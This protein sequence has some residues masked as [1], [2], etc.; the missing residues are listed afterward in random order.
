MPF[1]C[2]G[3]DCVLINNNQHDSHLKVFQLRQLWQWGFMCN[4]KYNGLEWATISEKFTYSTD[5]QSVLLNLA[6]RKVLRRKKK[7]YTLIIVSLSSTVQL[8]Q[9]NDGLVNQRSWRELSYMHTRKRRRWK[10]CRDNITRK[11]PQMLPQLTRSVLQCRVQVVT[12]TAIISDFTTGWYSGTSAS[13]T[14]HLL[15]LLFAFCS[16]LAA[17]PYRESL[18]INKLIFIG[19]SQW[20]HQ[21]NKAIIDSRLWLQCVI[22]ITQWVLASL[23]CTAKFCWNRCSRFGC[24]LRIHLMYH[25]AHYCENTTSSTIDWLHTANKVLVK[26]HSDMSDLLHRMHWL[27]IFTRWPTQQ[28]SESSWKH[29]ILL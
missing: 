10:T 12:Q 17:S 5:R 15:F 23:Y 14:N 6:R 28:S 19:R 4:S 3:N 25:R 29:A 18:R 8:T 20:C 16:S 1:L 11:Q 22:H 24:C 27:N 9:A 21:T 7:E 26:V 13:N 2:Q